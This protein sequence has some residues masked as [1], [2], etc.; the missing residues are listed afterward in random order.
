MKLTDRA[1]Q[2]RAEQLLNSADTPTGLTVGIK[3]PV[4]DTVRISADLSSKMS[5]GGQKAKKGGAEVGTRRGRSIRV[6]ALSFVHGMAET[7]FRGD[8]SFIRI[9]GTTYIRFLQDTEFISL[10]TAACKILVSG[11]HISPRQNSKPRE[12]ADSV[13]RRSDSFG[14]QT[15]SLAHRTTETPFRRDTSFIRFGG[16]T[17][18]R[19][20]HGEFLSLRC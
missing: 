19:P 10:K 12:E 3:I 5:G 11:K 14:V 9:G 6:Q 16:T 4:S 13:L 20:L 2:L 17:R 7:A 8:T 15:L 18:D 1:E